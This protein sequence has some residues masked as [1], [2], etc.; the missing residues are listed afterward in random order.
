MCSSD[1]AQGRV[2]ALTGLVLT[3]E[4]LR[5]SEDEDAPTQD[6]V[7]IPTPVGDPRPGSA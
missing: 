4:E 1:L 3:L 2:D 5:R 7:F 6:N